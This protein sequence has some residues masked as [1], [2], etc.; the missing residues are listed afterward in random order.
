MAITDTQ[1]N[2]LNKMCITAKNVGLGTVLQEIQND[3]PVM[4]KGTYIVTADDQT[5]TQSVIDTEITINGFLVDVYRSNILMGG[6]IVTASGTELTVAKNGTTY[7]LTAGD[8]INY[9]VF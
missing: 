2:N 5:A 8:V 3:I 4:A 1:K 7:V 9:I 6:Y